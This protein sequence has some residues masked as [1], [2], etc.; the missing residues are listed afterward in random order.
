MDSDYVPL[1]SP[2][3]VGWR[4]AGAGGFSCRGDGVVESYGGSGILWYAEA[5]YDDF[6]LHA[7]WRLSGSEDNSGI[8]LRIPPLGDDLRPAIEE[9]Y[10]AQI[11]DRGF[12]PETR[13][14]GSPPHLTG[15]IYKLAPAAFLASRPVGQW[16]EFEIA[17]DQ[18]RI[19]VGLNGAL[20]ARLD[21]ASRRPRGHIGL[22]A[23]HEGSTV[24]F[25]DLR[26]KPR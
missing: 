21:A 8:F 3:L 16:N 19:S 4:M 13:R 5:Q 11:D 6:I 17:A 12:D 20:V 10:E 9:G 25:R 2:G 18:A 1:L 22:Q 26:I 15:A 23:H 14:L 24:Q 7:A